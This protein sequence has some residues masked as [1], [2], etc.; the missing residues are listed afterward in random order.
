MAPLLHESKVKEDIA[1][2]MTRLGVHCGGGGRGKSISF[3][4]QCVGKCRM[5]LKPRFLSCFGNTNY[6]NSRLNTCSGDNLL[7]IQGFNFAQLVRKNPRG[8]P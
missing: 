1:R 8:K 3:C 5:D 4:V 7:D 6:A 2:V